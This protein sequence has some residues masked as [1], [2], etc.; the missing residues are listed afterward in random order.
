MTVKE[1]IKMLS[2]CD[3][4]NDEVLIGNNEAHV[5]YVGD[6]VDEGYVYIHPVD[7]DCG[8]VGP[9]DCICGED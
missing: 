6:G 9:E 4:W 5:A 3:D 8:C 2:S 1:L 7:C